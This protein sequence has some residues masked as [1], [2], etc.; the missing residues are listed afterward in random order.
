MSKIPKPFWR[1]DLIWTYRMGS[2]LN[3]GW[4]LAQD[5]PPSIY[6]ME[7]GIDIVLGTLWQLQVGFFPRALVMKFVSSSLLKTYVS[8][9]MLTLV[10][11]FYLSLLIEMKTFLAVLAR[12][13]EGFNL[14]TNTANM[15]WKEGIILTPK[16]GVLVATF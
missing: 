11:L 2:S 15:K 13:V 5:R 6:P 1:M 9:Q 4:M 8:M 3:D 16:D 10:I 12:K 7:R 14:I